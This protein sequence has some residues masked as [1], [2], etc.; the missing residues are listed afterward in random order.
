VE[1]TLLSVAL[2]VDIDLDP[3]LDVDVDLE[4]D[5]AF[6]PRRESQSSATAPI[7]IVSAPATPPTTKS[8]LINTHP[9]S[10][11][12]EPDSCHSEPD[13]DLGCARPTPRPP[14]QDRAT[15]APVIPARERSKPGGI[16]CS[17]CAKEKA[18]LI[19]QIL[20]EA[21]AVP[22]TRHTLPCHVQLVPS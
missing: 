2:D 16:R 10:C 3:D 15:Q 9:L 19:C 13:L 5:L 4:F 6:F 11:H 7:L 14:L 12:S 8:S 22:H 20:S 18:N 21:E 1:R 17:R